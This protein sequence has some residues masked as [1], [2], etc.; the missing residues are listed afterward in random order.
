MHRWYALVDMMGHLSPERR[1]E[2]YNYVAA[3]MATYAL[4]KADRLPSNTVSVG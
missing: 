1:F 3:L 4:S 2:Y